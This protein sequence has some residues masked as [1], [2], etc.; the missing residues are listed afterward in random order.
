MDRR[1]S[2]VVAA[3]VVAAAALVALLSAPWWESTVTDPDGTIFSNYTGSAWTVYHGVQDWVIVALAAIAGLAL[4]I[5][6]A[7][8]AAIASGL[9]VVWIIYLMIDGLDG[10]RGQVIELHWGAWVSLAA[11][12]AVLASSLAAL[13][14]RTTR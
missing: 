4:V 9:A 10:V 13:A 1:D 12:F 3:G 14:S 5:R 7:V 6:Q 11:A 2:V 8:I